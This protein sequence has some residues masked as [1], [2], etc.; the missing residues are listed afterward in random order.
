VSGALSS[1]VVGWIAAVAG[2]LALL[3]GAVAGVRLGEAASRP[4]VEEIRVT[5]PGQLPRVPGLEVRSPAGFTGFG[6]PPALEGEV[7][8]KG[9]A[10]EVRAGAFVL[11]DGGSRSTIEFSQT[12][13]LYR[14]APATAPLASGDN[15]VVRLEG[16]RAAAILRVR[17]PAAPTSR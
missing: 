2:G 6:G 15:V 7:L 8:R 5:D 9:A 10:A 1:R 14:V 11:V 13:R 12:L 17:L 16:G 4:A 3:A